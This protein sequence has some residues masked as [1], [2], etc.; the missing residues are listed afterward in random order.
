MQA[1]AYIFQ[2]FV[3][4][5]PKKAGGKGRQTHEWPDLSWPGTDETARFAL[6]RFHITHRIGGVRKEE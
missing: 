4:S 1:A 5:V 6:S 2:G 3:C